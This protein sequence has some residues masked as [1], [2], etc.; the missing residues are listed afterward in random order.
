MI[1]K[2]KKLALLIP[3][4]GG[5]LIDK[6]SLPRILLLLT[7]LTGYFIF[8]WLYDTAAPSFTVYLFLGLFVLRYIF[9]FGSFIKNGFADRIKNKLGEE[10]GFELYR[11]IT[12]LLFFTTAS[13]FSL[14]INKSPLE[15]PIYSEYKAVF[16][17]AGILLAASGF[18][19][20]IWS[21]MLVGVDIYY[22]KDLFVGRLISDFKREGPYQLFS[23][24]MY[25][26]G[27]ANGYGTALIY[28]SAGG[29]GGMLLN[30]MMMYLFYFTI[31]KPH[32]KIILSKAGAVNERAA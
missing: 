11:I 14:M 23:N 31:E 22:Y 32:I 7:I 17:G 26:P 16:M 1:N 3:A 2:I 13:S 4:T 19:I 5:I 28:G 9:L 10:K 21:A 27:Q 15:I 18:V 12:A 30:Q 8:K 6:I 25:G 29:L 24:P 20:N